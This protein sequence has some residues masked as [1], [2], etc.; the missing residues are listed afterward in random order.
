M[1]NNTND[2]WQQLQ[3]HD[4]CYGLYRKAQLQKTNLKFVKDLIDFIRLSYNNITMKNW[5]RIAP[6]IENILKED[7]LTVIGTII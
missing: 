7:K 3:V 4:E 1:L 5:F 2:I 6:L